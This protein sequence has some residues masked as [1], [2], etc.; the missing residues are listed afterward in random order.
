MQ[1]VDALSRFHLSAAMVINKC[2]SGII[3][4]IRLCQEEDEELIELLDRV[5]KKTVD[6]YSVSKGLLLKNVRGEDLVVL[7]KLMQTT[8]IR[9]I[10][11]QGHF[12]SKKTIKILKSNIDF[13]TWNRKWK[14][15]FATV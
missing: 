9:R 12:V 7:P 13:Q 10:H 8:L 6:D 3:E 5:N 15:L 14:R 4:K 11:D 1:H 2:E